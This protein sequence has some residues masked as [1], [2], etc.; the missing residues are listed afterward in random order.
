[1]NY[2]CVFEKTNK[3]EIGNESFL[4]NTI[5]SLINKYE[6]QSFTYIYSFMK[7]T[8]KLNIT[9][10]LG[11]TIQLNNQQKNERTY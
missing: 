10:N 4:A 9:T 8:K 6:H 3:T 5:S 2:F 1:M 7:E 11:K